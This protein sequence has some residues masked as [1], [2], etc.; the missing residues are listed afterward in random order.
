MYTYITTGTY[1]FLKKLEE[2]H[3]DECMLLMQNAETALL[4][5]ETKGATVFQ[6]PRKYEVI[7]SSGQLEKKGFIACNHVPVREEGRPVFEF[8]FTERM[9]KV[10]S[11][12]GFTAFRLL[13]P[14]SNDT[15]IV[16]TMWRDEE[17]YKDWKQSSSFVESHS[18][19]LQSAESTSVFSGPSYVSVFVLEDKKEEDAD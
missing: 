9:K 16:M 2:Q 12:P 5:H 15:Y 17:A 7:H 13:R 8:K 4:W 1:Y 3:P 19:A 6:S 18:K 11:F 10:E 14:L